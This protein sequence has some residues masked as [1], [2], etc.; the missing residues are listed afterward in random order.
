MK[1]SFV[2]SLKQDSQVIQ[3]VVD[4]LLASGVDFSGFLENQIPTEFDDSML[5]N[6]LLLIDTGTL[7]KLTPK[8]LAKLERYALTHYIYCYDYMGNDLNNRIMVNSIAEVSVNGALAMSGVTGGELPQQS[9]ETTLAFIDRYCRKYLETDGIQFNEFTFHCL[10]ALEITSGQNMATHLKC[11]FE[12]QNDDIIPPHHDALGVWAYG[13]TYF[14]LTGERRFADSM[15]KILDNT[16]KLR[17]RT[18]EGIMA[19][20]GRI[21]DPLNLRGEYPGY[22]PCCCCRRTVVY[23]EMLHFHGAVFAAAAAYS[24]KMAYFDEAILLMR[25]LRDVHTDPADG[26]LSHY[27]F[28]GIRRG[29]KWGRGIAHILWGMDLML[30]FFPDMPKNYR[31]EILCFFNRI[32]ESLLRYQMRSGLW[33]NVINVE[34]STP[35]TSAAVCFAAVYGRLINCGLLP[36][37][38][39]QEMVARATEAI[40]RRCWRGG[41]AENCMGTGFADSEYY[42]MKRGHN[43]LFNGQLALALNEYRKM[44]Q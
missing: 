36:K 12:L 16:M 20:V 22:E 17:P 24:G 1:I 7:A 37:T 33:H 38:K 19:G 5:Q 3:A 4:R 42:Y 40:L 10:R 32:G 23:N 13:V 21:D 15:L 26:L 14:Q 8:T 35:E 34:T 28:Q 2:T 30:Q 18:P 41:F 25:Y 29:S 43:F 11:L 31:N 6:Q 39:Y 9:I 27:S 44:N